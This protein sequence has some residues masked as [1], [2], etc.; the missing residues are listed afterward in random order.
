MKRRWGVRVS[1]TKVREGEAEVGR[2]GEAE[3]GSEGEHDQGEGG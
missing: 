3:V 2:E 1:M